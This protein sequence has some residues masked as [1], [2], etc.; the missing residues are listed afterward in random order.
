[1]SERTYGLVTGHIDLEVYYTRNS[2]SRVQYTIVQ[3][4]G[5]TTE[6]HDLQKPILKSKL[7]LS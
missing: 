6:N 1:M 2:T 3:V 7:I 5:R 4:R